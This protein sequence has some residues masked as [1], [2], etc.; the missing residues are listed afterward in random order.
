MPVRLQEKDKVAERMKENKAILVFGEALF[1][2]FP[3]G[4]RVLGGAPFNVAWHLQALENHPVFITRIGND[5]LGGNILSAM[6]NW[7][8]DTQSIQIDPK[9]QTGQ[10]EVKIIE[11]EPHYTITPN[12]A[13]DFISADAMECLPNSGILYHGTL[14]IRNDISR[15]CFAHIAQQPDLSIFLDVNLRSPW[16][17]QQEVFEWLEHARWVKLNEKELQQLG[18]ISADISES[19]YKLQAQFKLE[20]LIVTR[21]EKGAAVLSADGRFYQEHPP[22]VK[23]II[24]TVGAG[25]G[26]SALFIHG[27]KAGWPIEK[28]L[29]VAQQFASKV[30]GLR[31][32]ITT[33]VSFYQEFLL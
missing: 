1:D 4:E 12:C 30:I 33:E 5:G 13:Y 29:A 15:D 18:F 28:I 31:G 19:M 8:M 7:G 21:G 32:A 27:L 23:Y 25:D 11:N 3:D 14:G 17:K 2:C 9:Y 22:L 24:D 10:V 26:F 16:W 20:L 6:R